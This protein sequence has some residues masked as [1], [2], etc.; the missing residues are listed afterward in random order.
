[1]RT[2]TGTPAAV[3]VR[4]SGEA[5]S[6]WVPRY[7]LDLTPAPGLA[8]FGYRAD[9]W[10][11]ELD[12]DRVGAAP[13]RPPR[14][15]IVAEWD[16]LTDWCVVVGVA[17]DVELAQ[18]E[19][20][21]SRRDADRP[22]PEMAKHGRKG[23]NRTRDRVKAREPRP[24]PPRPFSRPLGPET[25]PG[26]TTLPVLVRA[27]AVEWAEAERQIR[28]LF[29]GSDAEWDVWFA[30][31]VDSFRPQRASRSSGRIKWA[32]WNLRRMAS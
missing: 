13:L 32:M 14:R 4:R 30:Q 16:D 19:G 10:W 17:T 24:T 22:K 15:P 7:D 31:V 6:T 21:R 5:Q 2:Y 11:D 20:R 9:V 12:L 8:E 18:L 28:P 23:G 25:R 26:R 27:A 29:A 3:N 1:M